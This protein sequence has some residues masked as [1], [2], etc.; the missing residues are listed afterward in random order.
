MTT[1]INVRRRRCNVFAH[2][3]VNII[4][5]DYNDRS[6]KNFLA[7]CSVWNY[8]LRRT[9]AVS[10]R[11]FYIIHNIIYIEI[12]FILTSF[13]LFFF[14][15]A[16]CIKQYSLWRTHNNPTAKGTFNPEISPKFI[17]NTTH[18]AHTYIAHTTVIRRRRR[19]G[20]REEATRFAFKAYRY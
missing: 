2:V 9:V 11:H 3:V 4:C 12:V 20:K 13:F 1:R 6:G 19:R 14:L 17:F 8:Y 5:N 7:L 18:P 15:K 16:Y 10:V